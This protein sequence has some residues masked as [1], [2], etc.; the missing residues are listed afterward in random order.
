VDVIKGKWTE[1]LDD[2]TNG[3]N[4]FKEANNI[5]SFTSDLSGLLDGA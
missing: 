5:L 4:M 3:Y 1:D 2:L